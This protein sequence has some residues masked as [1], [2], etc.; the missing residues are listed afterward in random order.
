MHGDVVSHLFRQFAPAR[1][2]HGLTPDRDP[3]HG[4]H[5]YHAREAEIDLA[6]AHN[7]F[8]WGR[9]PERTPV[10]IVA[11]CS[12]E[13][14]TRIDDEIDC[15]CRPGRPAEETAGAITGSR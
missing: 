15:P 13:R 9:D 8:W 2:Q 10:Q 1:D 6:L 11:M 7:D 14:R 12:V 4:F 3:D 5:E